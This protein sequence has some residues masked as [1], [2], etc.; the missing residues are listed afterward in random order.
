MCVC[1]VNGCDAG[2]QH[3]EE[4]VSYVC[5]FF[6]CM[7]ACSLHI[8][9]LTHSC[10]ESI[11][12]IVYTHITEAHSYICA[13]VWVESDLP[14]ILARGIVCIKRSGT[15]PERLIQENDLLY[16]VSVQAGSAVWI[17]WQ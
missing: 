4:F 1:K 15:D 7:H 14:Q 10:K 2:S 6:G 9:R 16:K 17:K 11:Q 3:I 5:F 8:C 13:G 12:M